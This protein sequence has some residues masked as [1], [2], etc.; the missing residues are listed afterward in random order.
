MTE[1]DR[2]NKDNRMTYEGFLTLTKLG[3]IGVCLVLIAMAVFL[4]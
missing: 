2:L 1:L 3:I 4:V